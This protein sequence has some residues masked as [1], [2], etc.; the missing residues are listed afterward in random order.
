MIII[1]TIK[2]T[3]LWKRVLSIILEYSITLSF[4]ES[5]AKFDMTF[6]KKVYSLQKHQRICED[7]YYIW[8]IKQKDAITL[9]NNNT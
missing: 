8:H 6:K 3:D 4:S 7:D 9:T 2:Y 5:I 1:R